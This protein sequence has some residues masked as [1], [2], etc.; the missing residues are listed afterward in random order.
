MICTLHVRAGL[1]RLQAALSLQG[2]G[3][4]VRSRR[5][6]PSRT[7]SARSCD[8]GQEDRSSR[9][10]MPRSRTTSPQHRPDGCELDLLGQGRQRRLCPQGQVLYPQT[11]RA[12]PLRVSL[13]PAFNSCGAPTPDATA[14]RLAFPS[15]NPPA[16]SSGFL[17]VGSPTRTIGGQLRSARGRVHRVPGNPST[18]ADEADVNVTVN[19]RTCATRP[20]SPTTPG[21]SEVDSTV[22]ITDR[23]ELQAAID[24]AAGD[25]SEHRLPDHGRLCRHGRH[26]HRGRVLDEH[27]VRRRR[28][29]LCAR[30]QALRSGSSARWS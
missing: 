26:E 11:E 25:C 4:P 9:T 23:V 2:C 6:A 17:T 15:C 14:R 28:P 12:T 5:P 29:G 13:V 22:Q 24:L 3:V 19:V 21:R 20:A 30:G 16:Q 1:G 8:G 7:T 10:T 18:P 27:L